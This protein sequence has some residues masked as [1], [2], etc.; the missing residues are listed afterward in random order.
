MEHFHRK[1][2]EIQ[3]LLQSTELPAELQVNMGVSVKLDVLTVSSSNTTDRTNSFMNIVYILYGVQCSLAYF[4][5][6]FTVRK[7]LTL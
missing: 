6:L 3:S 5:F 7:D 4:N 2:T 1:A